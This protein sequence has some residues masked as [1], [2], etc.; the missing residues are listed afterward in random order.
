MIIEFKYSITDLVDVEFGVGDFE[1]KIK[2][3]LQIC[4]HGCNEDEC[5]VCAHAKQAV[6]EGICEH[7]IV[8]GKPCWRCDDSPF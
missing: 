8:Y 3:K 2:A 5:V 1:F 7:G 4:K 6:E